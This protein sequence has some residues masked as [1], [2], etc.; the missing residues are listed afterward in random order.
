MDVKITLEAQR[1]TLPSLG[2]W[3]VAKNLFPGGND[4]KES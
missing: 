2:V 4:I 3:G 1:S